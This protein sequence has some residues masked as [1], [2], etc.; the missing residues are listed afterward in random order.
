MH[1]YFKNLEILCKNVVSETLVFCHLFV[2]L[3]LIP[4]GSVQAS[5]QLF[6][7]KSKYV[8]IIHM[9]LKKN[10]YAQPHDF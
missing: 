1:Y 10:E 4:T 6:K 2:S 8:D 7:M 9:T 5:L 3:T